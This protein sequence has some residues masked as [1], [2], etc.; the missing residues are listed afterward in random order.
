MRWSFEINKGYIFNRLAAGNNLKVW[1]RCM[2][3]LRENGL[4]AFLV[5]LALPAASLI[6]DKR[7]Y[8]RNGKYIPLYDHKTCEKYIEGQHTIM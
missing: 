7:K 8:D 2:G 4:K 5:I 6:V 1:V 3:K